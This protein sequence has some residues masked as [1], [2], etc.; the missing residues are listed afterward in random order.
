MEKTN[1]EKVRENRARRAAK[2]QGL[3]LKASRRRDPRAL[4]FGCYALCD[5]HSGRIVAGARERFEFTLADVEAYLNGAREA[6]RNG[7]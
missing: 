4:D 6:T 5:L 7:S 1:D 2:R 3:V